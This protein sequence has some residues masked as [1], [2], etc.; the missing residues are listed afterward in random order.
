MAESKIK[1]R[2]IK[3]I[4]RSESW[5]SKKIVHLEKKC[6]QMNETCQLYEQH[7]DWVKSALNNHPSH[8]DITNLIVPFPRVINNLLSIDKKIINDWKKRLIDHV[9]TIKKYKEN[10]VENHGPIYLLHL[11]ELNDVMQVNLGK[12][13][14]YLEDLENFVCNE[15]W[16]DSNI[17][18]KNEFLEWII[19]LKSVCMG[20]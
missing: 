4:G 17:K 16:T 12:V 3:T 8:I 20:V 11:K 7:L 19:L 5:S 13:S 2:P 10:T 15:T 14:E 1:T 6:Q 9:K 18:I